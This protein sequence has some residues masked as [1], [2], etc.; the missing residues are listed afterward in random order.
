MKILN[1]LLSKL[2]FSLS[3][4]F[5]LAN[6]NAQTKILVNKTDT[7]IRN[8]SLPE[9]NA[10][11]MVYVESVMG[12]KVDR[13]ECWDLA[14]QALEMFD[15]EWD[16]QLVF[17]RKFNPRKETVYPGDII[18]FYRVKL[19]Y[20]E[21]NAIITETMKQHTAIIYEVVDE[22]TFTIAQQNTQ[23]TGRK[24]GLGKINLDHV[25]QGEIKF[26][27]PID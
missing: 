20:E 11:I 6:C 27:R 9:L 23:A 10:N 5:S 13:G 25:V 1:T 26:Y 15:A 8:D 7:I 21:G 12:T 3:L 22:T 19:T 2:F 16:K 17:G 18:Q 24:V 14:Y 4:V